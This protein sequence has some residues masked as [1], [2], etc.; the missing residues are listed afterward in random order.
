MAMTASTQSR[1]STRVAN[2][3]PRL[4]ELLDVAARMFSEK[5]YRGTSL[6]DIAEALGMNK[7][8]LYYYV[9]SKEDLLGRLI[10]RAGRRLRNVAQDRELTQLPPAKALERLVREHCRV[11]F[12]HRDEMSVLVHQRRYLELESLGEV[13]SRERAYVGRLKAVI[14][15]GVEEGS[16]R[17]GDPAVDTQLVLDAVNGLLRWYRPNGRATREAIADE[18]WRFVHGGLRAR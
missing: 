3:P 11:A 10:L 7:A 17:A 9:R 1:A 14:A 6:S 15:R 2:N 8:S 4:E 18:I 16:F 12:E 5:G 13:S